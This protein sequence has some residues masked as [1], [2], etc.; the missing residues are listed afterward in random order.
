MS[1]VDL[2]P[3]RLT[4][5]VEPVC[6]AG[7]LHYYPGCRESSDIRECIGLARYSVRTRVKQLSCLEMF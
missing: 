7:S 6:I 1:D 2:F 5:L 4:K 3:Y